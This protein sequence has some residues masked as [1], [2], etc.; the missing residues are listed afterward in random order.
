MIDPYEPQAPPGAN[1]RTRYAFGA[2]QG[3]KQRIE[4]A[5]KGGRHEALYQAAKSLG[6]LVAGDE[7]DRAAAERCLRSWGRGIGL[8]ESEVRRT[9][10][11]GLRRGAL[12]PR[13][14]P[15]T[16]TMVR[17]ATEARLAVVRF[18]AAVDAHEWKGAKGATTVKIITA[19][20]MLALGAGRVEVSESTRQ[21][22]EA[23]GVSAATVSKHVGALNPWVRRSKRG[24]FAGEASTWRLV[25][26]RGVAFGHTPEASWP[27]NAG[28]Y[29]NATSPSDPSH[30]IWYQ[31]SAAFVIYRK[32]NP[33][34]GQTQA[35]LARAL[36]LHRTTVARNLKD[37]LNLG[38]AVRES[39]GS[40]VAVM[41][42]IDPNEG[43]DYGAERRKRH[44]NERAN[45]R[46]KLAERAGERRAAA[47]REVTA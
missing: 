35:G 29:R 5:A 36:G 14:A 38:L 17:S 42:A 19:F 22:A 8:P 1:R 44:A 6:R 40:W 15:N 31:R 9:I 47:E 12:K 46:A 18:W 2:L 20:C 32:L 30:N 43:Y 23:A 10:D 3:E 26:S 33:F 4:N 11:D 41:K 45:H 16:P 39:D 24:T 7:L 27:A 13:Q 25:V 28:M 37:L 21:I 34:E